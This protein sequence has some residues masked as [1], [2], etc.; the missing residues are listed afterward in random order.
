MDYERQS[1]KYKTHILLNFL[2]AALATDVTVFATLMFGVLD[3]ID[4]DLT[5]FTFGRS[6]FCCA[7]LN[8]SLD[9]ANASFLL[10][11]NELSSA[12]LPER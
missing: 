5:G 2:T 12:L 11:S 4:T 1:I 8:C 6:G 7:L 9:L 10:A 3:L